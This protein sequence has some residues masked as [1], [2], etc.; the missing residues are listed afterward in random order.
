MSVGGWREWLAYSIVI[1]ALWL[2][3]VVFGDKE[4]GV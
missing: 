3:A 4:G 2:G 1:T